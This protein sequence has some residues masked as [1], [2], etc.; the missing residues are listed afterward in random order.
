MRRNLG[1][2]RKARGG[3]SM[4]A[5][6]DSERV[7]LNDAG[8][9]LRFAAGHVKKLD[10]DLSLAIAEA[11][12]AAESNSWTPQISQKFCKAYN[13]L[14]TLIDP[15]T[16]DG[17]SVAETK[18]KKL[19]AFGLGGTEPV[20]LAERTS[21][22]YSVLLICLSV[23]FLVV[24]LYVW[25]CT[26]LSKQ[27][28]DL[29]TKDK[30]KWVQLTDDYA[31]LDAA[32]ANRLVTAPWSREEVA[33]ADKISADA[34]SLNQDLDRILYAAKMLDQSLQR[35][36]LSI[37]TSTSK[38][39]L[40]K[41]A[42]NPQRQ[43]YEDYHGA[44]QRFDSLQVLIPNIQARANLVVGILGAFI[45]PLLLGTIGAVAYVIRQISDQINAST[46]SA[47]SRIRHL[48]RVGLGALAGLVVGV[49][50]FSGL[51]TQLSLPPLAVAFLAGYGVEALFSMFDNLIKKFR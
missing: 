19:K 15:V 9:L 8:P 37:F 6:S 14:C 3:W 10:P 41:K 31:K 20:S 34:A 5:C 28:D 50:L 24:Q 17:L 26:N 49:G 51:T 40:P 45:L 36:L 27:I 23:I 18:V 43:W 48:T 13:E 42:E 22:R 33:K 44:K 35:Q 11:R 7:M 30:P 47:T 1:V 39:T 2:G 21:A 32:T 46:F 38:S 4:V 25:N 12:A 29:S 16:I